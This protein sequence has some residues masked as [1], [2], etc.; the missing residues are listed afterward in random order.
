M[1]AQ[2]AQHVP[3][4]A[5]GLRDVAKSQSANLAMSLGLDHLAC[6][7]ASRPLFANVV[8]H[9]LWEDGVRALRHILQTHLVPIAAKTL[10]VRA[11]AG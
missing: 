2:W 3:S 9:V 11:R 8:D 6:E 5:R 4:A 10:P 1:D 7:R